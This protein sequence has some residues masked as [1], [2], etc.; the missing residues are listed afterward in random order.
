MSFDESQLAKD[1]EDWWLKQ[2]QEEVRQVVPKSVEYGGVGRAVDLVDI[3]T[4][5]LRAMGTPTEYITPEWATEIGIYF[6]IRGKMGRWT[7]ALMRGERVSDDTLHDISVYCR[8][9]QRTRQMG[10]WPA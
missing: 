3:G 10:G 4:D 2:A 6:Y 1:L 7:A 5:L 9:A 8:M